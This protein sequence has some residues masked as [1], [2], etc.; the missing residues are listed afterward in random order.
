MDATGR[1]L[2]RE[3]RAARPVSAAVVALALAAAALAIAQAWLLAGVI[4]RAF[5]QGA[6]LPELRGALV[7][8][9]LVWA[10]RAL[11]NAGFELTGRIGA[12]AVI[13]DLRRRLAT[14]LLC[15]RP[16]TA[17]GERSGELATA[18]VQGVDALEGWFARYL[19]QVVMSAV[20]P[21]AIVCFLLVQ[22]PAAAIV[23]ALTVPV[24]IVFM[25]LIGLSARQSVRVRWRALALLG[26][27]FADV[28][29]GLPTLRAHVRAGAQA[30]TIGDIS[31]RYRSATMATLRIAFLSALVLEL[32]AMVGTALVAATVGLQLIAGTIVLR[33]GLAVL[34]LAPELYAPLRAVGQQFHAS[35][36]GLGA[37]ERI[38]AFLDEP[39][40]VARPAIARPAPD[41]ATAAVELR[42]VSFA[43]PGGERDVLRG[44]SLRIAPGETVAIVGPSGEGKST[45]AALLLRLADPSAGTVACAGVD[46]RQTDPDDWR[47]RVAWMPQRPIIVAG[48]VAE[49]VA[50]GAPE[51]TTGAIR[52]ALARAGAAD[53]VAGLADGL[54]TRI[55]D[56]GR[57]LS[58][59]EAQRVALARALLRDAP[60]LVL[61]EPTAHLDAATAA[62]VD[63]AVGVAARGRSTV[64]I[65]HRPELAARAD[66]ILELRDGRL[67]E[68]P[69]PLAVAA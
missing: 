10:G 18:A 46:L 52:D 25:V 68:L 5:L 32:V 16:I 47:A 37:A 11:V 66:R 57:R 65:A 13:G 26:A 41:P 55:G 59:G 20:V 31:D 63:D 19:P 21:P 1:R 42:D 43:Y 17:A 35:A 67:R 56:G 8:L 44:V 4:A 23:L 49:N 61:D 36:D 54:A 40:T 39:A 27:H 64:L 62:A 33:S 69:A 28:V 3:S 2:L 38:F 34:V 48:T 6:G 7:A 53:L 15:G 51:A 22:D 29:R 60:L 14:Q 45:L 12:L 58:A 30:A 24:L 50:L 9:V